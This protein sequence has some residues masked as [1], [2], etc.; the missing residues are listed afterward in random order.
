MK[1]F[2][3]KKESRQP[4]R[5]VTSSLDLLPLKELEMMVGTTSLLSTEPIDDAWASTT[6]EEPMSW[7]SN[8]VVRMEML[9]FFLHLVNRLAFTAGGPQ[10]RAYVQEAIAENVVRRVI[11]SSFDTHQAR[12]GFDAKEWQRRV[13]SD[14]VE[15]LNEAEVDYCS[16]TDLFADARAGPE[17]IFREDTIAGRLA[18]RIARQVGQENNIG[19]RLTIETTAVKALTRSGLVDQVKKACSVLS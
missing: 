8:F 11:T 9:W 18:G 12:E 14:A 7:K 17:A 5:R 2:K 15:G 1:W 4:E 16:C 13:I 19:L 6:G 3:F 10:A